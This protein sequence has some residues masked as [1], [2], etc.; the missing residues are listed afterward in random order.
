MSAGELSTAASTF[1]DVSM[2]D[3]EEDGDLDDVDF[4]DSD[5]EE[6]DEEIVLLRQEVRSGIRLRPGVAVSANTK[7]VLRFSSTS[8]NYE[9]V[10]SSQLSKKRWFPSCGILAHLHTLTSASRYPKLL[11][12]TSPS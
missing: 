12:G 9:E 4:P 6:E 1:E 2:M 3:S 7:P 5:E 11:F 8:C 10:Q